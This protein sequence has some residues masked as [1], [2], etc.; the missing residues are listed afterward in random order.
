MFHA[1][2]DLYS[3]RLRFR[4]HDI[5][6]IVQVQLLPKDGKRREGSTLLSSMFV[7]LFFF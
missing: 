1:M 7:H 2:V 4:K 5:T 3:G 6:L